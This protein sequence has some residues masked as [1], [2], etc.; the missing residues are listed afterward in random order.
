[1][2]N[3]FF[4]L[5]NDSFRGSLWAFLYGLMVVVISPAALQFGISRYAVAAAGLVVLPGLASLVLWL[6]RRLGTE[7]R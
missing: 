1:M 3:R 6:A 4:S 7:P 5:S 2:Q